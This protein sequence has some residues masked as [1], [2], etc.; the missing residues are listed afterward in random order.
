M[1][2]T[3]NWELSLPAGEPRITVSTGHGGRCGQPKNNARLAG[4]CSPAVGVEGKN[5]EKECD[6][7]LAKSCKRKGRNGPA[8]RGVRRDSGVFLDSVKRAKALSLRKTAK[9]PPRLRQRGYT[10]KTEELVL[11]LFDEAYKK[12]TWHG[13]NLRQAIRGVS[14]KQAAGRAATQHMGR[15]RTCGVL[16]IRG[17]ETDRRW[18]ERLVCIEGE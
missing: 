12:K 8:P 7:W 18:K 2:V 14:A 10:V 16:E 11:T 1:Q 9:L 15:D 17:A 4:G 13:P 6:G 3:F 5:P